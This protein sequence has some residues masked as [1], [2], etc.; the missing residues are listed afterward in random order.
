ML[1]S[2]S[3]I[4][5]DQTTDPPL[6]QAYHDGF[7]DG[8]L[9]TLSKS[10]FKI[11]GICDTHKSVKTFLENISFGETIFINE[12]GQYDSES[13]PLYTQLFLSTPRDKRRE[14][15]SEVVSKFLSKHFSK[16]HYFFAEHTDTDI[17]HYHVLVQKHIEEKYLSELR[18]QFM[19]L[20]IEHGIQ[21][22]S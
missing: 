13:A 6:L 19:N 22:I 3:E 7:Y 1:H 2:R 21:I 10:V 9:T 20:C 16:Q 14:K 17:L 18:S 5:Y 12:Y 8:V 4:K 11:T 15:F